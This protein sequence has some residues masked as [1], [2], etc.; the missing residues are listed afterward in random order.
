MLRRLFLAGRVAIGTASYVNHHMRKWLKMLL[1]RQTNVCYNG[2][3][4]D[5][6]EMRFDVP[7]AANVDPNG[8]ERGWRSLLAA[9]KMTALAMPPAR[10]VSA[11]FRVCGPDAAGDIAAM[12]RFLRA[13]LAAL[14][15]RPEVASEPSLPSPDW[16][17]V[18]IWL[19]YPTDELQTLL[20]ASKKKS[21]FRGRRP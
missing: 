14:P 7:L 15:G 8:F 6:C 10:A 16:Q 18:K 20:R 2:A 5:L 11:R 1:T 12:D 9:Q 17:G 21:P 13:R 19:S 4:Q 3:M